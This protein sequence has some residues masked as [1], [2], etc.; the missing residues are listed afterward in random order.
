[1]SD[2]VKDLLFFGGFGAIGLISGWYL[3]QPDSDKQESVTSVKAASYESRDYDCSDFST[4]SEAQE[5]FEQ[6]GPGDPDRLDRD[7][8]GSACET[9]P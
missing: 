5:Y 8:D 9:L 4:H 7:G 2:K 6:R 3:L 1:M